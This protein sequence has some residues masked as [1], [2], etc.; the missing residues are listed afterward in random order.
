ML[1]QY[2]KHNKLTSFVRQLNFYGFHKVKSPALGQVFRHCQFHR[3]KPAL[4]AG[5]Q[6]KVGGEEADWEFVDTPSRKWLSVEM[7]RLEKQQIAL[8]GTVESMEKYSL[9][10]MT[11]NNTMQS[12]VVYYKERETR[13]EKLIVLLASY[14]QGIHKRKDLEPG[15]VEFLSFVGKPQEQGFYHDRNSKMGKDRDCLVTPRE[16][17]WSY[18]KYLAG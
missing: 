10:L 1:P 12:Q 3:D 18:M 13:I 6:R 8:Q 2:F 5:I 4:M 7:R 9:D 14:I 15:L 16:A 17:Q 11:K